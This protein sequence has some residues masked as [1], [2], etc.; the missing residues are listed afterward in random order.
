M[1]NLLAD[2]S[3]ALADGGIEPVPIGWKT[4][5]QLSTEYGYQSAQTRRIIL[6]AL[7][8]GLMES[9]TFRIRTGA[10]VYPVPHYRKVK[11]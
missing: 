7:E 10:R 9:R 5:K 2:L 11:K 3:A 8:A 4:A 6:G 1:A